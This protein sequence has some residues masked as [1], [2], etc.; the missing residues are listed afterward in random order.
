[1]K[2]L[3]EIIIE[4]INDKIKELKAQIDKLSSQSWNFYNQ[5]HRQFI[6]QLYDRVYSL[7]QLKKTLHFNFA[8]LSAL[9]ADAEP[10][11]KEEVEKKTREFDDIEDL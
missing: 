1:M 4:N 9:L 8:Q 10:P 7:K 6:A 11:C 5:K 3:Y 2:I